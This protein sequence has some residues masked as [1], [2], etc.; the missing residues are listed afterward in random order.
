MRILLPEPIIVPHDDFL[1]LRD[2]LLEGGTKRRILNDILANIVEEEIVYP[3][4]AYGYAGLALALSALDYGKKVKLFFPSPRV[5]TEVFLQLIK[6]PNVQFEIVENVTRQIDLVEMAQQY[7]VKNHAHFMP[8]GFNFPE[9]AEGLVELAKS[10]KLEPKEV[11]VLG[12]SGLLSRSLT[13]AWPQAKINVVSLG[14]PQA[15]FSESSKV[16]MTPEKPEDVAEMLP[17]YPSSKYYDAKIWR[18]VKE[19]GNKGALVWNVA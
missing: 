19:H 4:H 18:F 10:L 7:A 16:Y 8:V 13:K 12:G 3:A 14:F 5:D 11:W 15:K 17:P 9:F 2:D 6:L 1:V